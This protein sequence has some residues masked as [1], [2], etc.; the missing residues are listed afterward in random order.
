MTSETQQNYS[1]ELFETWGFI[2]SIAEEIKEQAEP[3]Q[4]T[5]KYCKDFFEVYIN[6]YTPGDGSIITDI[7]NK[8][9]EEV[10]WEYIAE[11]VEHAIL[12]K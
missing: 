3:E 11:R 12:D 6:M 1:T 9:I 7:L 2:R 10:D 5:A 8:M 4:P